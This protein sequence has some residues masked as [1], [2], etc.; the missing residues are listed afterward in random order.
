MQSRTRGYCD[1]HYSRL[2]RAGSLKLV[3]K[4]TFEDR[5]WSHV[6]IRS[7][8]ECWFWTGK[9]LA[10]YGHIYQ[11]GRSRPAHRVA[12]ELRYGPI[13]HELD[14]DHKCRNRACVN[15][16]HIQPATRSM[17]RQNL[18]GATQFSS[19]GVRGVFWVAEAG[20]YRA[21]AKLNG[22]RYH[23]GYFSDIQDAERVVSAWRRENMPNSLMDRV[24]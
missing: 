19:T 6:E 20:K 22:K 10:G 3:P 17:N 23:L 11:D 4:P 24:A 8:D 5:F 18:D 13:P 16:D 14:A 2:R 21:S 12:Y 15:P 1:K 7:R 9:L